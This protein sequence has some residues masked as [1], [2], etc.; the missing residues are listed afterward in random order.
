MRV[1]FKENFIRH[2]PLNRV[3]KILGN[4][5]DDSGDTYFLFTHVWNIVG[6]VC[7]KLEEINYES[8]MIVSSQIIACMMNQNLWSKSCIKDHKS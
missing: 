1:V 7:L 2:A 3:K 4:T 5:R 6:L 8:M